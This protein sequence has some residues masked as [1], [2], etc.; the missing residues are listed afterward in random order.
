MSLP[1][2]PPSDNFN[3]S[4]TPIS[5]SFASGCDEFGFAVG[6]VVE[7]GDRDQ[8]M[9]F[10]LE[11]V[12][13]S[14]EFEILLEDDFEDDEIVDPGDTDELAIFIGCIRNE[15][16]QNKRAS[17]MHGL[18]I[19]LMGSLMLSASLS[20]RRS[21]SL[22]TPLA[23]YWQNQGA[24][25]FTDRAVAVFPKQPNKPDQNSTYDKPDLA[26]SRGIAQVTSIAFPFGDEPLE[27]L[28][29][30]NSLELHP[31]E[32][33]IRQALGLIIT[34]PL[35]SVVT[36]LVENA[37][38]ENAFVE[39]A[40]RFIS[41]VSVST[42]NLWVN[43]VHSAI[44]TIDFLQLSWANP[45]IKLEEIDR[46]IS[47]LQT[48]VWDGAGGQKVFE[49][50]DLLTQPQEYVIYNF[51]L[52][53][54][55]VN[56]S[57]EV[58]KGL[59]A[60]KFI[61]NSFTADKLQLNQRGDDLVITFT[62]NELVKVIL[63]DRQ[64]EDFDNLGLKPVE[65]IDPSFGVG[66]ILFNNDRIIRDTIDVFNAV[67]PNPNTIISLFNPNTTTFFNDQN[68]LIQ[69]FNLSNDIIHGL[70]GNDVIFGLSGNDVI[71]GDDGNDILFGNA[72]SNILTGGSGADIFA[73]SSNGFSCVTDFNVGEGDRIGLTDGLNTSIVSRIM[74]SLLKRM[75]PTP[76]LG[77]IPSTGLSPR[78]SKSSRWRSLRMTLTNSFPV[79]VITRS[80][81][82]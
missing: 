28:N 71:F 74:R 64:R 50:G 59:D 39:S 60:L 70:G 19:S 62:G 40:D 44:Q 41:K 21:S 46:P 5:D 58:R 68:N 54:T 75:L 69:G 35:R 78:L 77:S 1:P 29:R 73:L 45:I 23:S 8:W 47:I 67:L 15:E 16:D 27:G 13:R 61:G 3:Y 72:G 14:L 9:L 66:N 80:L 52:V 24:Y 12:E 11:C 34:N 49:I 65:G 55:G 18:K 56:P 26:E 51:G 4:K 82:R 53:G 20:S 25:R 10:N 6:E 76:K 42:I 43:P 79:K 32:I 57:I 2:L 17:R 48:T 63:K 7:D 31:L 36:R 38:V 22:S 33:D 30:P 81:P 37:F